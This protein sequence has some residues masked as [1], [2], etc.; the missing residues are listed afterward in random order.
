MLKK[1]I[2]L[3]CIILPVNALAGTLGK[4]SIGNHYVMG[5]SAG[6]TWGSGNK[7][8][9][10]YL[11]PDIEK[12]YAADKQHNTFTGAAFFFGRQLPLNVPFFDKSLVAQLGVTLA[13]A[14]NAKLTGDIWEDADPDFNNYN[15]N[16]KINHRHMAIKARLINN[17]GYFVAPFISASAGV[18]FNRAYDF[19]ITPKISSEV[20]APAFK[21]HTKAAFSYALK[22]GLQ[23][24]FSTKLHA[25]IG[26]EWAD[27][28]R[29]N[30]S[31]ANGQRLN[32]GLTLKHAYAQ[33][34]Q[35]A[36]FYII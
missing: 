9:T 33:Q 18:G 1:V 2:A 17:S 4:A 29:V 28:G 22:I 16:Y 35:F 12:T 13:I 25:A 8:Q 30:L 6:P 21:N 26:Y 14:G 3:Y 7:T 34:L 19:T 24:S 11:Q 27:W 20:A 32:Q 31:R 10:F 5:L 36:L 15:Y 23:K